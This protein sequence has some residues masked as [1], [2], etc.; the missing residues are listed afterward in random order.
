MSRFRSLLAPLAI[1][2]SLTGCG[3][4]K[5]S[6]TNPS[7]MSVI[8]GKVHGGQQPISGAQVYLYAANT[9]AYGGAPTPK[10][11]SPGYVTTDADGNFNF[12]GT[13]DLAA[14][15][16]A[17]QLL[18]LVSVGGNAGAGSN[19]PNAVLMAAIG[20]CANLNSSSFV[21]LNEVTTVASVYALQQFMSPGT[22]NVGTSSTNLGAAKCVSDGVESGGH[23]KWECFGHYPRG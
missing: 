5:L 20:D 19:N 16:A 21:Y 18:Y 17:H 12:N 23:T 10:L 2:A 3:I 22:Y 11:T 4:G 6:T 15:Q 13:Y 1:C 14:C 8:S 7:A 9:S